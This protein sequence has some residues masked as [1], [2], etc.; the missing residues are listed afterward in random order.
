[1]NLALAMALIVAA[2]P[3]PVI[4][5]GQCLDVSNP[6]QRLSFAG[7]L[8]DARFQSPSVSAPPEGER[9]II[10]RIDRSICVDDGGEFADPALRFDRIH[11]WGAPPI[12]EGLRRALRGRVQLFG[13]VFPAHTGH[14]HAPLVMEVDDIIVIDGWSDE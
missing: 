2:T 6:A 13:R 4:A 12:A 3:P 11:V 8:S 1:M 9:A 10:L 5:E 7:T 14:H